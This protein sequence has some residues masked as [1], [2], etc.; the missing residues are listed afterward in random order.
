MASMLDKRPA[1]LKDGKKLS[2]LTDGE[3]YWR[4]TKGAQP[5]PSFEAKLNEKE[6]WGLVSFLRKLSNTKPNVTPITH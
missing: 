3:I 2:E 5:M 4:I 6:R 1:D